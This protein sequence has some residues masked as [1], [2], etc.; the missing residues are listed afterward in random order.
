MKTKEDMCGNAAENSPV[1][2]VG[3]IFINN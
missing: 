3:K 1:R 2:N